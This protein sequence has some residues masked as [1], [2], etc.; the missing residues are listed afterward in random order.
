MLVLKVPFFEV[1]CI[2]SIQARQE[3]NILDDITD[4]HIQ[5]LVALP[6]AYV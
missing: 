5:H 3:Q 2:Y 4:Q 1:T 6:I